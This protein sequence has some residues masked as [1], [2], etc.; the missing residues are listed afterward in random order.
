MNATIKVD[1][2]EIDWCMKVDNLQKYLSEY[3]ADYHIELLDVTVDERIDMSMPN[4]D[5]SYYMVGT[6]TEQDAFT[7]KLN[8]EELSKNLHHIF[9]ELAHEHF[10]KQISEKIKEAKT[11]NEV[12]ILGSIKDE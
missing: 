3:L 1:L 6:L 8:Q 2:A 11:R 9:M 7:F 12:T 10:R 4:G 5:P